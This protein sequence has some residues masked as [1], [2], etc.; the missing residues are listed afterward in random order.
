MHVRVF[1]FFPD[2]GAHDIDL[3]LG[4]SQLAGEQSIRECFETF[5]DLQ[6]VPRSDFFLEKKGGLRIS[7]GKSRSSRVGRVGWFTDQMLIGRPASD[8]P[9]VFLRMD[10]GKAGFLEMTVEE[11]SRA[12]LHSCRSCGFDEFM[13]EF[14]TGVLGFEGPVRGSPC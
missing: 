2:A 12:G 4:I 9:H 14:E 8:G 13:V 7:Y 3:L 10:V 11:R 5:H 6:M 1:D